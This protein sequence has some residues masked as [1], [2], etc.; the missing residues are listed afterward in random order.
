MIGRVIDKIQNIIFE[1]D[2]NNNNNN[3]KGNASNYQ[4][5]PRIECYEQGVQKGRE[6]C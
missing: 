3:N 2:N 1:R 5:S 6:G 4:T